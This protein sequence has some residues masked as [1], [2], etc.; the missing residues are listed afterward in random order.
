MEN[1]ELNDDEFANIYM[2]L[3]KAEAG[4][5]NLEALYEMQAS[6]Q[7]IQDD[8]N[9][10][11]GYKWFWLLVVA[12]ISGFII[13]FGIIPGI[14]LAY[15]TNKPI[16]AL[17]DKLKEFINDEAKVSGMLP[18]EVMLV[19]WDLRNR[20][21]YLI[22]KS[23][24]KTEFPEFDNVLKATTM[25]A[26][27]PHF[28]NPVVVDKKTFISGDANA[29]SPALFAYYHATAQLNKNPADIV[30]VSVGGMRK[31]ANK[32]RSDIGL[33]E[34][35]SRI[36]TLTGESKLHSQD[37]LLDAILR[38]NNKQLHK[39][40]LYMSFDDVVEIENMDLRK[41]KLIEAG[42]DLINENRFQVDVVLDSILREKFTGNS[43]YPNCKLA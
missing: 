38:K 32:I 5:E 36:L 16:T 3:K 35:A 1:K 25:S 23:Q 33:T 19:S 37:Y 6:L 8:Y 43:K 4:E 13:Y 10:R 22:T 30:V 27:S 26:A 40:E 2:R 29:V 42:D 31:R 39:F 34:W 28:F 11:Q 14:E 18:E 7:K 15:L 21:P 24:V 20:K 9:T 17:S 12:T 41:E